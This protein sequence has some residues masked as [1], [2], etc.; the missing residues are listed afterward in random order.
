[1]HHASPKRPVE[2]TSPDEGESSPKGQDDAESPAPR[3]GSPSEMQP[4]GVV[5]RTNPDNSCFRLNLQDSSLPLSRAFRNN[6][7]NAD[8]VLFLGP[9]LSDDFQN[10]EDGSWRTGHV[11]TT[12]YL[13]LFIRIPRKSFLPL[14]R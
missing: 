13:C 7:P 12:V 11:F 9:L 8:G 6:K 2:H 14:I 4:R 10:R 1:M 3:V 5:S